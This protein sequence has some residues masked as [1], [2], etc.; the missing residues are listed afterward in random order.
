M[1]DREPTG[2]F[3]E[4]ILPFQCPLMVANQI[5]MGRSTFSV[6]GLE[7]N[8]LTFLRCSCSSISLC[9]VKYR[10]SY[11]FSVCDVV[12]CPSQYFD[13]D[14]PA[15]KLHMLGLCVC[16]IIAYVPGNRDLCVHSRG[17]GERCQSY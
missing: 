2:S 10:I 4:C 13:C 16:H 17:T 5:F 6:H 14:R 15:S 7:S 3:H 9:I 12:I 1:C 8:S 11:Y